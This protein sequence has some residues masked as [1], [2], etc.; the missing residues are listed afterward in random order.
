MVAKLRIL[1]YKLYP[2]LILIIENHRKLPIYK[3]SADVQ[4]SRQQKNN[5]LFRI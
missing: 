3:L 5:K 1:L 2:D 4:S